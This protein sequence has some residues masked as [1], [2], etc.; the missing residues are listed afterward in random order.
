MEFGTNCTES[1]TQSSST[2]TTVKNS[3]TSTAVKLYSSTQKSVLEYGYS[4]IEIYYVIKD[5][6][7]T[8]EYLSVIKETFCFIHTGC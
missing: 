5:F 8:L 2:S 7:N 6:N 4:I 1:I 3:N